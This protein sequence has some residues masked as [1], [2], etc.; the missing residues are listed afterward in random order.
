MLAPT[1]RTFF[2]VSKGGWRGIASER[3]KEDTG[4]TRHWVH[5]QKCVQRDDTLGGVIREMCFLPLI[6]G[7]YKPK[8]SVY[9]D[10]PR[11][12]MFQCLETRQN[13]SVDF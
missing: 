7:S 13:V 11:L 10:V 5:S 2:P 3:C 6:T 8:G 9:L 12:L 1:Y 4:A